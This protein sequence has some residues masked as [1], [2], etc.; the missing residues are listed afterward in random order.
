MSKK[1]VIKDIL[2]YVVNSMIGGI[3]GVSLAKGYYVIAVLAFIACSVNCYSKY[4]EC[5]ED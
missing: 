4:I 3:F 2:F 1:Q 5:S